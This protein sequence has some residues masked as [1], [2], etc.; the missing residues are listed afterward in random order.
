MGTGRPT[1]PRP[2][3]TL[4]SRGHRSRR[5]ARSS[6]CR[7]RHEDAEIRGRPITNPAVS[8]ASVSPSPTVAVNEEG[9]GIGIYIALALGLLAGILVATQGGG[10]IGF[11]IAFVVVGVVG[12]LLLG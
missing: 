1:A 3:A 11:A 6:T 5:D 9:P 12:A 7:R 10:L 4:S 8:P 2:P